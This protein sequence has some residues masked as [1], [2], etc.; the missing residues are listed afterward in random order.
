MLGIIL[1]LLTI[2]LLLLFLL[3]RRTIIIGGVFLTWAV[4]AIVFIIITLET[5]QTQVALIFA[6]IVLAPFVLLF[7]FYFASLIILLLTSGLQLIKKEGKKLRNFLSIVLGI[8][9]ILWSVISSFFTI[10]TEIHPIWLEI[11]L[12]ITF[13]G[14]YLIGMLILFAT[15]SL[16]NRIPIPFKT[17]DYIIVL[18][19]GLIGDKVPPLL[20]NRIDK[21][22]ALFHRFHTATHP[23]KVIFTGGQGSDETLAE[24]EAM[25]RYALENGMKKEDIIIENQAVNTYENLLFSKRL[26]EKDVSNKGHSQQYQV[27]T[28]TNNFHVFRALLWARKVKL[29]SDGA[30]AKTKF[31]FWLNALIREFI[32]VIYMQRKY[33]ISFVISGF[34]IVTLFVLADAFL[35]R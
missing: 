34:L 5:Y 16:I 28:V 19:S 23:V 22:I 15:S 27:I 4:T 26:I 1:L 17:Y 35:I 21:G 11:Y 25:A 6:L 18:G 13:T 7:P 8:G 3:E 2:I 30:G 12:L 10:S 31:Y 20:A 24:G 9:F 29:K 14:Y 33:H 32:G